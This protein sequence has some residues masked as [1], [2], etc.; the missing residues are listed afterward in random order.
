M[1]K[2][3][4]NYTPRGP[5]KRDIDFDVYKERDLEK[6]EVNWADV[7]KKITGEI[8]TIRDDRQKRKDEIQKATDETMTKLD[9][10]GQYDNKTLMD[11]VIDG[12]NYAANSM[13]TQKKLMER[14]LVRP[15]DYTKFTSNV[16]AGFKTLK[17][18]AEG[19]DKGF[20]RIY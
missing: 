18:T 11:L 4:V 8:E 2:G 6:T 1:A 13:L 17:K 12:S 5:S 16:S 20:C 3:T 15:Q 9:E 14:G 19:W 10:T 7:A